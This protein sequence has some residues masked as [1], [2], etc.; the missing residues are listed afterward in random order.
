MK[1]PKSF[2]SMVKKLRCPFSLSSVIHSHRLSCYSDKEHFGYIGLWQLRPIDT[3][4]SDLAIS[5]LSFFV[6]NPSKA[7]ISTV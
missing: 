4:C 7:V 6:A 3:Q 5:G 2:L 1:T